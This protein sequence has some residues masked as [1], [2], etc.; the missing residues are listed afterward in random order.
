MLTED[1]FEAT[2]FGDAEDMR[3]YSREK[4]QEDDHKSGMLI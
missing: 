3:R 1:N 4:S 2:D